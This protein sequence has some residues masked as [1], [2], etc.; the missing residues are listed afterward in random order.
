VVYGHLLSLKN[1]IKGLAE[2]VTYLGR[3][4][5]GNQQILWCTGG[6][7]PAVQFAWKRL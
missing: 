2:D 7:A 4:E 6:S 5:F 3:H 1:R